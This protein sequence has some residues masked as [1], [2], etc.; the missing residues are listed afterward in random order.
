METAYNYFEKVRETH[1]KKLFSRTKL[2]PV[3]QTKKK[4]GGAC[5]FY[6]TNMK[7]VFVKVCIKQALRVLSWVF[8][9]GFCI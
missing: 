1:E 7:T 9:W 4:F 5:K 2:K 6:F 3:Y 8:V